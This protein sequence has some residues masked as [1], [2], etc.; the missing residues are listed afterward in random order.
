M[1][2][3]A[4]NV[5]AQS[6]ESFEFQPRSGRFPRELID[7]DLA[8]VINGEDEDEDARRLSSLIEDVA[9]CELSK[10]DLIDG[11]YTDDELLGVFRLL[12]RVVEWL[13]AVED[14]LSANLNGL[15]RKCDSKKRKV[16]A[17]SAELARL[18]V[19]LATTRDEL[20]NK[21]KTCLSSTEEVREVAKQ[22]RAVDPSSL[23]PSQE[24]RPTSTFQSSTPG[25]HELCEMPSYS[26]LRE[27]ASASITLHVVTSTNASHDRLEV[28]GSSTVLNLK[29]KL[30]GRLLAAGRALVGVGD[31]GDFGSYALYHMDK[32]LSD[33]S[34][35]LEECRISDGDALI[36]MP[37]LAH[38][39]NAPEHT[40]STTQESTSCRVEAKIDDLISIAARSQS[41]L[42]GVSA[43][44]DFL[45]LTQQGMSKLD[46]AREIRRQLESLD[47]AALSDATEGGGG[48]RPP[49]NHG[50]PT[51]VVDGLPLPPTP[52]TNH[53]PS[54]VN[55]FENE[56]EVTG[57]LMPIPTRLDLPA[58]I[59]NDD[60]TSDRGLFDRPV[61]GGVGVCGQGSPRSG[62]VPPSTNGAGKDVTVDDD[63]REPAP[64]K[65]EI[66]LKVDTTADV[67]VG[68][69]SPF[70]PP[71]TIEVRGR[72]EEEEVLAVEGNEETA[73]SSMMH[74]SASST[75][76]ATAACSPSGTPDPIEGGEEEGSTRSTPSSSGCLDRRRV[77]ID[78]EEAAAHT[79]ADEAHRFRFS[80]DSVRGIADNIQFDD[81]EDE[82]DAT[83]NISPAR[84]STTVE[85][86]LQ[87]IDVVEEEEERDAV[88]G[89]GIAAAWPSTTTDSDPPQTIDVSR[90]DFMKMID[91]DD[92]KGN[93]G[94][95]RTAGASARKENKKGGRFSSFKR[96]FRWK[97]KSG[98]VEV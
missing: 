11:G 38:G 4:A 33:P 29:N 25:I 96:A 35:T 48:P 59:L 60:I 5:I 55:P 28:E 98:V 77:P 80:D 1:A 82:Y 2:S 63:G 54:T 76:S 43:S 70:N 7:V 42:N 66:S 18:D 10:S 15:A 8:A 19:E 62:N 17:L 39:G 34:K 21:T 85:S 20:H 84:P 44:L 81:D 79:T 56:T 90:S 46:L 71:S 30:V 16:E 23:Y 83:V 88:V 53:T 22:Q 14:V 65:A 51:D 45:K 36:L 95:N 74:Y 94:L 72:S 50:I 27:G 86:D 13:W 68:K 37:R 52:H 89:L 73:S 93:G 49:C 97:S 6:L 78:G 91:D 26:T 24:R 3:Y 61:I 41:V 92:V 57:T 75:Q 32:E 47:H 40:R 58:D 31:C 9:F 67:C 12:Q 87:T 69:V 64:A